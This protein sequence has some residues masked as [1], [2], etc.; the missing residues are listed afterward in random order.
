[1]KIILFLT[2]IINSVVSFSQEESDDYFNEN[3]LRYQN[4]IYKDSIKSVLLYREGWE[5]SYPAL[6][7]GSSERLTLSF[8]EIS[9]DTKDY[10]FK[11]IHCTYDWKPSSLM[12]IEYISGVPEDQISDY[13]FSFNTVIDYTHYEVSFPNED[14]LLTKSGN[15]IILV[16]EDGDEENLV[17]TKRFLV[18]E[19]KTSIN[20][21]VE[22]SSRL[23]LI[24]SHQE[25]NFI[26]NANDLYLN[27]PYSEIKPV[28]LQNGLWNTAVYNIQPSMVKDKEIIY[29]FNENCIFP[30]GSEF[31]HF[32]SKD[33]KFIMMM[34][35]LMANF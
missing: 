17:L 29:N 13:K 19:P 30:G 11:L 16:Y 2:I 33:L 26:V 21:K 27:D 35:T 20:A 6:N 10:Y 15:Y 4:Y 18:Y 24:K 8:D 5:L 25:V 9:N 7:I 34:K 12:Q 1:M 14:M 28:I 31:R 32:D 22:R 23:N 3:H